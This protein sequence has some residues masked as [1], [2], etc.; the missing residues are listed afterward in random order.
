MYDDIT[1]NFIPP[2]RGEEERAAAGR[3]FCVRAAVLCGALRLHFRL[4]I[5]SVGRAF[6]KTPRAAAVLSPPLRNRLPSARLLRDFL[7]FQSS[8]YFLGTA[9][10]PRGFPQVPYGRPQRVESKFQFFFLT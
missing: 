10:I 5:E 9:D 7:G 4:R 6:Q 1:H 3:P 8:V 2:G